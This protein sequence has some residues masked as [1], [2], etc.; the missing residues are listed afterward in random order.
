VLGKLCSN[1]ASM[2]HLYNFTHEK[3]GMAKV[4]TA[5]VNAVVHDMSKDSD[6][7]KNA[8]KNGARNTL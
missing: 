6:Y 3:A 4:D 2:A 5:H 1:P 8:L 7:Y